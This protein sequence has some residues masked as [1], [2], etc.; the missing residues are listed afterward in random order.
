ML[1]DGLCYSLYCSLLFSVVF[2]CSSTLLHLHL[3]HLHLL[4]STSPPSSPTSLSSSFSLYLV[5]SKPN[6][7][8]A[9]SSHNHIC[10]Q[11]KINQINQEF[12]GGPEGKAEDPPQY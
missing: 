2:W 5:V 8:G 11:K 6:I 10:E 3:L 1:D 7:H 4:L 9:L 12:K